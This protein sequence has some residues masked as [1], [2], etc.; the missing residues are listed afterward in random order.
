MTVEQILA[1]LERA[2]DQSRQPIPNAYPG[3]VIRRAMR[4]GHER[5]GREMRALIE[6][7]IVLVVPIPCTRIDGRATTVNGYQFLTP[8]SARER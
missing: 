4:W 8:K 7:G 5:F 1:E 6:A 3:P 2:A